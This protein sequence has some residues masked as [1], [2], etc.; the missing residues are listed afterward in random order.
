MTNTYRAKT[1]IQ[2]LVCNVGR[3]QLATKILLKRSMTNK[4]L[5]QTANDQQKSC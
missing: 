3:G 2:I 5:A 1:T 4:N